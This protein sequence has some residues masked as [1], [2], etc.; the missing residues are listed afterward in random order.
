MLQ[1]RQ[2]ATES[3]SAPSLVNVISR[4]L[5]DF[6]L[7]LHETTTDIN[8][9]AKESERQ[10]PQF[11]RLRDSAELMVDVNRKIDIS[12]GAAQEKTK[13]GQ[14]ELSSCRF[15]M[16]EAMKCMSLL[17]NTNEA[18]ERRLSEVEKALADVAGVSKAIESIAKQTNLL[19]LN[20]TIEASR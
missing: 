17:L 7:M 20:A 3:E 4:R 19:A 11:K 18:I 13:T 1:A 6:G 10:V 16:T 8:Q 9:A 15:A 5:G 14:A 2:A 12:S